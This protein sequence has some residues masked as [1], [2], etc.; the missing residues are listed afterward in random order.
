MKNEKGTII[1]NFPESWVYIL[2]YNILLVFLMMVL[3]LIL[4][5]VLNVATVATLTRQRI[6]RQIIFLEVEGMSA[7]SPN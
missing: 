1:C 4:I 7:V 6:R 5:I 3:P 2:Y